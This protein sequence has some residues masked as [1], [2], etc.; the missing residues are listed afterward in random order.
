VKDKYTLDA[1]QAE[2]RDLQDAKKQLE[3]EREQLFNQLRGQQCEVQNQ[4]A[5]NLELKRKVKKLEQI[6][7]GRRK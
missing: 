5:D 7:Y 1:L 6:L 2:N 4:Q 3:Q